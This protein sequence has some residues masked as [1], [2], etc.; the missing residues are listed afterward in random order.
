M[1]TDDFDRFTVSGRAIKPG[2]SDGTEW[3]RQAVEDFR[4]KFAQA[5]HER[6][7]NIIEIREDDDGLGC[8]TISA[9][10][11]IM[12]EAEFSALMERMR[13]LSWRA[14]IGSRGRTA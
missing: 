14:G 11:V 4:K 1:S 5:A 10:V 13:D 9:G 6:L 7:E 2:D 8:T 12:P 3:Q